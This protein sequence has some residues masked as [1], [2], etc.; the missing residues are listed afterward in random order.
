MTERDDF[1]RRLREDLVRTAQLFRAPTGAAQRAIDA[2]RTRVEPGRLRQRRSRHWVPPLAAA[3]VLIIASGVA[4]VNLTSGRTGPATPSIASSARAPEA[5]GPTSLS[6]SP[7]S[8]TAPKATRAPASPS[9]ALSKQV[10]LG[11]ATLTI[12][13]GWVARAAT[14]FKEWPTWCLE[15]STTPLTP[16]T[17]LVM[18]REVPDSWTGQALDPT[19]EGGLSSNPEYC[20]VN[21]LSGRPPDLLEY[22]DRTFGGR[23][24][25]YRRWHYDCANGTIYLIE[26]YVVAT[27]PGY[28]LFSEHAGSQVHEVMTTI[29]KTASVPARTTPLRYAD[30]GFVRSVTHEGGSYQ[31]TLDRVVTSS[32]R[33]PIN[34]NPATY[35]YV[36]P[37]ATA[38]DFKLAPAVGDL[39]FIA[40]DGYQ[41]KQAYRY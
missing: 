4:M 12:P 30:T 21:G 40:T 39:I 25:D 34:N 18:F 33:T 5:S 3:A 29:A 6:P 28:V 11:A 20:G 26:Q 37:D 8:D 38:S 13:R 16:A 22:G 2:A 17:C 15:P 35:P 24:A 23:P 41:V 31:I 1:E 36:I 14:T 27:G 32:R 19:I 7:A 9:A 10:S